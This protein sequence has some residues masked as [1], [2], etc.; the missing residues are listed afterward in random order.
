MGLKNQSSS[1]SFGNYHKKITG[2]LRE[3][4]LEN[5]KEEENVECCGPKRSIL[6]YEKS[7]MATTVGLGQLG[8]HI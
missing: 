6:L 2:N 4:V 7:T 5:I 8:H 3:L 1:G